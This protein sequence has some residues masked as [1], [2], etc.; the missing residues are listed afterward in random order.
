MT[1]VF[2]L[3]P[4][5]IVSSQKDV[6]LPAGYPI[7]LVCVYDIEWLW[8]Y[9]LH[10]QS[11]PWH[12]DNHDTFSIYISI[13]SQTGNMSWTE[14]HPHFVWNNMG[15]MNLTTIGATYGMPSQKLLPLLPDLV[16]IW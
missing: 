11:L 7:T 14:I 1:L 2:L 15:H 13:W 12:I 9:F 10:K 5:Q 4:R 6:Q 16:H 3:A 8:Q